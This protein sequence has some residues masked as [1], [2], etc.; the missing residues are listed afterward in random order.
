MLLGLQ[1]NSFAQASSDEK[2][3]LEI[4][5][6]AQKAI[7][8]ENIPKNFPEIR[9]REMSRSSS[10]YKMDL[11]FTISERE[12][13]MIAEDIYSFGKNSKSMFRYLRIVRSEIESREPSSTSLTLRAMNGDKYL[14]IWGDIKSGKIELNQEYIDIREKNGNPRRGP[15][16]LIYN[17]VSPLIMWFSPNESF[18][19]SGR[20][21]SPEGDANIVTVKS[22]GLNKRFFFDETTGRLLMTR[23]NRKYDDF[24]GTVWD[25]TRVFQYF[26]DF[27]LIDGKVLPTVV[28]TEMINLD[29]EMVNGEKKITSTLEDFTESQIFYEFEP[30]FAKNEFDGIIDAKALDERAR[31]LKDYWDEN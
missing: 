27:Q 25:V 11:G 22:K 4:I 16:E 6:Q 1:L 20:A 7:Y 13:R 14:D 18:S 19:Y 2:R 29:H 30:D 15:E 23:I 31:K 26:S 24:E 5:T 17:V 21:E 28:K 10:V 8:G 9:I 3:G 12:G